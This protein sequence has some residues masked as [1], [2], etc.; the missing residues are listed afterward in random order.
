M[1][2]ILI[3]YNFNWCWFLI[4]QLKRTT[5]PYHEKNALRYIIHTKLGDGPKVLQDPEE[6]LLDAESGLPKNSK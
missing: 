6:S 5:E 3:G 1:H 4:E 2:F